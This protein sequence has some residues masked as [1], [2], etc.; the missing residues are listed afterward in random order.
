MHFHRLVFIGTI[1]LFLPAAC[2]SGDESKDSDSEG[3][4]LS[5]VAVCDSESRDHDVDACKQAGLAMLATCFDGVDNDGD[6]DTDCADLGLP[7]HRGDL[8]SKGAQLLEWR[9]RRQ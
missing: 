9:G 2:S 1:A 8:L 6:G 3:L 4:S 7:S 5:A